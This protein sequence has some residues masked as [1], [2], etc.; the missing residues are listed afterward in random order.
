[1][2]TENIYSLLDELP[3]AQK[4]EVSDFIVFLS[5]KYKKNTPIKKRQFGCASGLIK[6]SDDF[7]EPLDEFK[8]YM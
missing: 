4:N 6:I 1:M 2:S 7:D 5:G 8:E 3:E